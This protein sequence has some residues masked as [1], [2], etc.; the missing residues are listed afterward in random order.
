MEN[1]ANAHIASIARTHRLLGDRLS[2]A[3]LPLAEAGMWAN[4]RA[5]V[6]AKSDADREHYMRMVSCYTRHIRR[7]LEVI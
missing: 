7:A 4:L 2:K 5:A 1:T 6:A 3:A